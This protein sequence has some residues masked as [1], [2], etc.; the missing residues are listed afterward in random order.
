MAAWA[1]H[2]PDAKIAVKL[3][4]GPGQNWAKSGSIVATAPEPPG[5]GPDNA[6]TSA[7]TTGGSGFCPREHI[8]SEAMPYVD[9][10]GCPS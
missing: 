6:L 9:A 2:L 8:G 4:R 10:G 1:M 7:G 5:S 3:S